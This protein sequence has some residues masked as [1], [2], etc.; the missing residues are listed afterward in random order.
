MNINNEIIYR[1]WD[2]NKKKMLCFESL[3]DFK[4]GFFS[5]NYDYNL[6]RYTGVND[7][8][9]DEIYEGD[10]VLIQSIESD[11][12]D[13][14]DFY[15]I[16]NFSDGSFFIAG[17]NIHNWNIEGYGDNLRV[18]GN[19]YENIELLNK[20]VKDRKIRTDYW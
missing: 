1:A 18:V 19:V 3:K 7:S 8:D 14:D 12:D 20:L 2:K 4:I 17:E 13:F 5:N 15:G 11:G 16:V 6:M 10:I 9:W